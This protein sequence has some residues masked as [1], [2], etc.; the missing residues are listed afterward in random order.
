MPTQVLTKTEFQRTMA[1]LFGV[2]ATKDDLKPIVVGLRD[3][4]QQLASLTTSV[5]K[6]GKNQ[7]TDHDEFTILRARYDRMAKV[8]VL[9]GVTT[10]EELSV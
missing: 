6:F 2:V 4:R 8:L 5:D 10:E 1:R 9:K 3:A 7:T